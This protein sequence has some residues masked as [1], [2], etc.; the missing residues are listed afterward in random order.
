[1]PHQISPDAARGAAGLALGRVEQMSGTGSSATIRLTGILKFAPERSEAELLRWLETQLGDDYVACFPRFRELGEID[2]SFATELEYVG[3]ATL[4]AVL[5]NRERRGAP[6][7]SDVVDRVA[8]TIAR[9]AAISI[10]PETRAAVSAEVLDEIVAGLSGN[11]NA[12][13]VPFDRE[14]E[15]LRDRWEF[16]PVL[17][18]RDLS[19]VNVMCTKDGGVRLIDPRA[20]VPGAPVR[21]PSFGSAAID[22]AAFLVS[23][24]RKELERAR[25]DLP[26]LGL[27]DR[28]R[29][30]MDAW[31]ADGLFNR[32]MLDLCLALAYSVYAACRCGYCLAYERKWLY[33]LMCERFEASIRRI[34]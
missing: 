12:A 20:S 9:F 26:A 7:P 34:A 29:E 5:A 33:A 3:D 15:E 23:L 17:C 31:M 21:P 4:E 14:V 22:A 25:I 24:E 1:M 11:A 30:A 28:F 18:H 10:A 13:G 27:A 16:V 32:A 6:D 8:E 19:A 2:G